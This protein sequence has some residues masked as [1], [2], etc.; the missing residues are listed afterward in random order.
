MLWDRANADAIDD[1][2]KYG[3]SMRMVMGVQK[4]GVKNAILL[5]NVHTEASVDGFHLPDVLFL[6]ISRKTSTSNST[7]RESMEA[8]P[9]LR[10]AYAMV[11]NVFI[12]RLKQVNAVGKAQAA[13]SSCASIVS[14]SD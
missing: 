8:L 7:G 11:D 5:Q 3:K 4:S 13:S 12:L 9:C 1:V 10:T 6:M 14:A 2:E